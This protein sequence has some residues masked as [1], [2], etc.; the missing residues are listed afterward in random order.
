MRNLFFIV[1]IL[2]LSCSNLK[3]KEKRNWTI[4]IIGNKDSCYKLLDSSGKLIEAN[5]FLEIIENTFRDTFAMGYAV[6]YP[7]YTGEF[8]YLRAGKNSVLYTEGISEDGLPSTSEICINAYQGRYLE[9][10]IVIKYFEKPSK[11]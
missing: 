2:L 7:G 10:K 11:K 5:R 4:E 6:V 8:R 3:P 1:I 9:G